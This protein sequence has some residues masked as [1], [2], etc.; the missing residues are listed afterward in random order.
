MVQSLSSPLRSWHKIQP[1]AIM[2]MTSKLEMVIRNCDLDN[3]TIT[4]HILL[5]RMAA[6][7]ELGLRARS[8]ESRAVSI[9]Y[10]TIICCQFDTDEGVMLAS[11]TNP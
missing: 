4:V 3:I 5:S 11:V 9:Y 2:I 1:R 8:A 7:F 10:I 6:G